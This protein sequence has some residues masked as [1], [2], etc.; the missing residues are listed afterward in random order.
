M[1]RMLVLLMFELKKILNRK[2]ALLF[3]IA[4]NVVPLVASVALLV[5]Y[6][7]FK[8]F[9]FGEVQFSMLYE[10]V[11]GLFTAHIKLFAYIAPFFL[12]LVVGDS[13]S[14]EFSRGYMKM[15][16]IT[17]VHRWQVITAKTLAV[18]LF[19]LLAVTIGGIFLQ[20]DLLVARAITQNSG[21]V[22]TGILP[23]GIATEKPSHLVSTLAA[24]QLLFMTFAGNLMLIGFFILFSLFFESAIIMTFTSLSVLMG[25]HTYYLIA[26]N[27]LG[28]IDVWY[29]D[30]AQWVFSRH[31]SDLFSI[32]RIENIL[33]GKINLFSSEVLS[34]LASSFAWAALFYLL[35]MLVFSRKQILH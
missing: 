22:G 18:M 21:L 20:A 4:L 11:Q 15:L 14:T 17:P 6:V 24:L 26:T 1:K 5:A 3:L 12:A 28:K 30:V 34:T 16:L 32:S 2:K 7:K 35:A 27:L 10:V 25:L 33:E 9:G 29:A 8:G 13:F 19:L 31:L 23:E